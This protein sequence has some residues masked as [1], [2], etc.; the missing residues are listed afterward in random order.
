MYG[1]RRTEEPLHLALDLEQLRQHLRVYDDSQDAYLREVLIPAVTAHAESATHRQLL[2]A[3]YELVLDRFPCYGQP[4]YVPAPPLQEVTEIAYLDSAGDERTV[5]AADY[6]YQTEKEPAEIWPAFGQTWPI[7]RLEPGAVRVTFVAG[8]GDTYESVPP[9]L[10]AGMLLAAGHLYMN[11]ESVVVGAGAAI[12]L[13]MATRE[14]FRR[15]LVGDD[16]TIYDTAS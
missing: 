2:T 7:A 16:F 15:H 3:T 9:L 6:S 5:A 14:I 12:E 1:L 4:I 13:P 8:Y 11:R 10:R